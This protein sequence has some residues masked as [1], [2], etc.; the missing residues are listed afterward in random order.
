MVRPLTSALINRQNLMNQQRSQNDESEENTSEDGQNVMSVKRQR[1][2]DNQDT[3]LE[4]QSTEF[5]NGLRKPYGPDNEPPPNAPKGP[6]SQRRQ[7]N[8]ATQA[9][10]QASS[11][12]HGHKSPDPPS[13]SWSQSKRWVSQEAKERAAF[14]K[15]THSLRHM[16][17]DKS[18]FV[19]QTPA[20][21]AA[22]RV[23]QAERSSRKLSRYLRRR[24][25]QLKRRK[26]E[27]PAAGEG[28]GS[29]GGGGLRRKPELFGGKTPRDRFSIVFAADSCFNEILSARRA[30]LL[31]EW[32]SLLELKEEG[33]KR[34]ARFGRYLPLP[35][36]NMLLL[37]ES[38]VIRRDDRRE[39][40]ADE[41]ISG[42]SKAVKHVCRFIRPV[43]EEPEPEL[44]TQPELEMQELHE[45]L[46]NLLNDIDVVDSDSE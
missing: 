3:A 1:P 41:S 46:Q 23:Q 43:S 34:A 40:K 24:V 8:T 13:G 10:S 36:M 22:F 17:A 9:P 32:P 39:L 6:A 35:R 38:G 11:S 45:P 15:L 42:E 33:D 21:L 27:E 28:Q 16:G 19:P 31:A 20:E 25:E 4:P 30:G 5:A 29:A 37:V 12:S 26:T 7:T 44:G 2:H 14:Q 18:P